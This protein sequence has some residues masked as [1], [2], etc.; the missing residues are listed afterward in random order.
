MQWIW[1]CGRVTNKGGE[2]GT[3]KN[4]IQEKSL[5]LKIVQELLTCS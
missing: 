2:E 1:R 5:V 4:E 3:Y